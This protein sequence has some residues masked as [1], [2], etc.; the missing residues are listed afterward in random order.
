[1]HGALRSSGFRRTGLVIALAAVGALAACSSS[2][3]AS[4]GS[5]N[6]TTSVTLGNPAATYGE[7][8]YVVA[9]K[10]G[11][12]KNNGITSKA[13]NLSSSSTLLAALVSGGV[14]FGTTNGAAVLSARAQGVPVV[15]VCGLTQG[16]PGLALVVSPSLMKSKNLVTGDVNGDLR[17]LKGVTIGVNSPTATGGKILSGLVQAAGLSS[18]WI[19]E[20]TVSSSSMVT[21]LQHGEIQAYFQDIPV[22]QQS[23]ANKSGVIA[24]D[25][26][27]VPELSDIQ[28][29]VIAA[30]EKFVK[31]HKS[32]VQKFLAGI[33]QGEAALSS[34]NAAAMKDIADI[35]PGV[36]A[37]VVQDAATTG[38]ETNCNIPSSAWNALGS[39]VGKFGITTST[40]TAS[41][42]AAAKVAGL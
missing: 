28:Y 27:N 2:S 40:P 14:D 4:G 16:V 8:A 12:L 29:N 41:Q 34:K 13:V 32:T 42:L 1:M 20:F 11:F 33:K 26:S 35:Y 22:P 15:A 6:S 17:K 5:G 24:F 10:Q 39:L 3:G 25:T 23:V 36:N 30:S 21:A 9:D 19:K 7:S 31:S 18:S 37:S 38:V